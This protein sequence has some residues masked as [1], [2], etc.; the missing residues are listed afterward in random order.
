MKFR[1]WFVSMAIAAAVVFYSTFYLGHFLC[2]PMEGA[3]C[4]SLIGST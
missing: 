2:V 4:V 1:M 3:P